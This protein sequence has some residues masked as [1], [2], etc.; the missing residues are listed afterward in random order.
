[1]HR[2]QQEWNNNQIQID[3]TDHGET[4]GVGQ[5][6]SDDDSNDND[7]DDNKFFDPDPDW[8][9]VRRSNRSNKGKTTTKPY[10]EYLLFSHAKKENDCQP[11]PREEWLEFAFGIALQ[12]FSIKAG[13]KKFGVR[14]EKAMT[15]EL[16]QLHDM[17]TFFPLDPTKLTK[18]R[19]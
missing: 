11:I 3:D 16:K 9:G 4:T 13:L 8:G 18:E 2:L 6:D 1:M 5:N 14:G 17:I 15:K 7:S 19:C 10:D 12:Q